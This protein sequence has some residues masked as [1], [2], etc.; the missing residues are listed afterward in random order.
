M[1]ILKIDIEAAPAKAYIWDLKTRYVP[2]TQVAEDGY[3]LCYAWQWHGEDET[4]LS[5]RWDHGEKGMV[6]QAWELLDEADAVIHYNGNNYDIPRLN[7]EFLRYRLGPPSPSHQIDLYKVVSSK[8]RVLSRSMNHILHI[9]DLESKIDHKGM[10][11]WT[12]CMAGVKEDQHLME[13]Y[14]VRDVEALGELYEELLPWIDM[15]PN[16]GLYMDD[17]ASEICPRC[18]SDDLRFKGYKRTK[19]QSYRQYHCKNCGCYPRARY[20]ERTGKNKREDILTW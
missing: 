13:E 8:F 14:N 18:G 10:E 6:Q 7:T 15:H 5:T 9:L 19:V 2:I 1:R 12:N 20:A 3:L 4:Y 11:L 17:Q 16:V